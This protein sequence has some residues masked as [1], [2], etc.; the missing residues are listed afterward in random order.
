MQATVRVSRIN[1]KGTN[2]MNIFLLLASILSF[3]LVLGHTLRGE[4]VGERTLVRR[5]TNLSLFD[6]EEKDAR[7]KRVVRVA[8]HVPSIAWGGIG[9][10]LF[11]A[12]LIDMT[13]PTI[14]IIRIIS[15]TFFASA[16]FSLIVN[17]GKHASWILFLLT[18][19]FAWL[20][21]V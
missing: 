2:N 14:I 4:W 18:S 5:I 13:G 1:H 17:R 7:A 20:G 15:I 3:I 9:A 10:I 16:V 21:T 11:Y 8:W 19:I 12:A 6:D